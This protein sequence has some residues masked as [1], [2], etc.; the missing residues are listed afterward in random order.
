MMDPIEQEDV[1]ERICQGVSPVDEPCNLPATVHCVK[2]DQWFCDS[3]A[4]D[5]QWHACMLNDGEEGGEA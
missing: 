5:D 1:S 2:C 3:H 4:E